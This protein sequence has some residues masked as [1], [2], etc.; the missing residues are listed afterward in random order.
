MAEDC[1]AKFDVLV[2]EKPIRQVNPKLSK[3]TYRLQFDHHEVI[4]LIVR[5]HLIRRRKCCRLRAPDVVCN[6]GRHL[7]RI[8]KTNVC[9]L[10]PSKQ[11]KIDLLSLVARG[12]SI[13]N[14]I[15]TE[16]TVYGHERSLKLS[17]LIE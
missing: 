15:L 1:R 14:E 17:K 2:P 16:I 9:E 13:V 10:V 6:A 11:I 8:S 5:E 4:D 3:F 7:R 12:S